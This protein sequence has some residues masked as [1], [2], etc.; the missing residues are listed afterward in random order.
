MDKAEFALPC[1]EFSQY[2]SIQDVKE[3]PNLAKKDIQKLRHLRQGQPTSFYFSVPLLNNHIAAAEIR[4]CPISNPHSQN[5]YYEVSAR[6]APCHQADDESVGDELDQVCRIVQ[7]IYNIYIVAARWTFTQDC[8]KRQSPLPESN[9]TCHQMTQSNFDGFIA[10]EPS[11]RHSENRHSAPSDNGGSSSQEDNPQ[12]Q[13]RS[14]TSQKGL[15]TKRFPTAVVETASIRPKRL[16][17]SRST[18][19]ITTAII[20]RIIDGMKRLE[21]LAKH[22]S[23]Q[24]DLKIRAIEDECQ[25]LRGDPEKLYKTLGDLEASFLHKFKTEREESKI[26]VWASWLYAAC[27]RQILYAKGNYKRTRRSNAARLIFSIVNKLLP[28]EGINALTILP[29]LG[30]RCSVL[31]DAAYK[32]DIEQDRISTIVAN[33]LRGKLVPLPD[34]YKVYNPAGW[35]SKVTQIDIREAYNHLGMPNL[36]VLGV[37]PECS[38]AEAGKG[39]MMQQMRYKWSAFESD[40]KAE[41]TTLQQAF[42]LFVAGNFEQL[43]Q[44]IQS[45][46]L[47]QQ[48]H[49]NSAD[50]VALL[51]ETL[52]QIVDRWLDKKTG[53]DYERR[54][55]QLS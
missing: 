8:L 19:D 40:A 16:R 44:V 22:T 31:S 4:V 3:A 12:S 1:G 7:Q 25:A 9:L 35:I 11:N 28:I 15:K 33:G 30:M 41:L 29:A 37:D 13:S 18:S 53:F 49:E 6:Y 43:P 5:P 46:N 52:S 55:D 10:H 51:S 42:N 17:R 50:L 14:R 2:I 27:L 21:E 48:A 36:A 24:I 26:S 45:S 34:G 39:I 54:C 32:G 38:P 23:L 47:K 20:S